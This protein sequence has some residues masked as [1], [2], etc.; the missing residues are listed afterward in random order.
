MAQVAGTRQSAAQRREAV[1]GVA[2][3]EFAERGLHGASTDS[4]ARSAGISQPYLFRLFRTK[5]ELYVAS[6]E[7]CL[8]ATLEAF[9]SASDGLEGDEAL[10]AM[11][12]AYKRLLDDRTMLRAQL[13]AYAA[14][15]DPDIRKAVRRGFGEIMAHVERV[16]GASP[17]EVARWFATGMLLNVVAAMDLRHAREPW[18]QRL[19]AGLLPAAE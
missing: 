9:Q 13:Q 11:G 16:S 8:G 10:K 12:A 17:E 7:H 15:D 1:L 3:V 18:A 19:L 6:V 4:I 14:C 5:K 2:L